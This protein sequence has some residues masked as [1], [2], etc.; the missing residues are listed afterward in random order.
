VSQP[1]LVE[2]LRRATPA[3]SGE[4]RARV[5]LIAAPAPAARTRRWR[6]RVTLG[7]AGLGAAAAASLLAVALLPSGAN[8]TPAPAPVEAAAGAAGA[9][10]AVAHAPAA[11]PR[12]FA[13][14]IASANVALP[15][16]SASRAQRYGATVD[17]RLPSGSA[18][19]AAARAA[20]RIAQALGG[21]PQTV[22]VSVGARGGSATI[23]VRVPRSRVGLAVTRLSALGVVTGEHVSISDLQAGVDATGLRI[24]HL[25][26]TLAAALHATPSTAN[27]KLISRLQAQILGLQ[28]G[29]AATLRTAADATVTVKLA[30]PKPKPKPKPKPAKKRVA[31]GPFHDLGVAFRYVGIGLVYAL[32]LGLPLAAL[33]ALGWFVA[34]RLRRRR[35]ERL[36]RRS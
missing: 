10:G 35:V 16:T 28:R 9:A 7:V 21:Y 5:N 32:A 22:Q 12:A 4:L 27:D 31:H 18:V 1:E 15:P 25:E 2:R 8:K 26:K 24:E 6:L 14:G 20:V 13:P 19:A 30:T 36:L 11:L 3:A 34:A 17:L 29:R 33:L 23:V